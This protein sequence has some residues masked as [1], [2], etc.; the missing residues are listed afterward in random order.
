MLRSGPAGSLPRSIFRSITSKSRSTSNLAISKARLTS[1]KHI[2]SFQRPVNQA[3][4][5]HKPLSISLQ[6]YAYSETKNPYEHIDRKGE[7]VVGK[8]RLEQHPEDVSEVSSVHQVFHEKG[9][10]IEEEEED[11][12]M[13]AGIKSDWVGN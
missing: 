2:P 5:T 12:D 9:E 13:L 4:I 11:V 7:A 8:E 3:L 1:I 6:K 10:K